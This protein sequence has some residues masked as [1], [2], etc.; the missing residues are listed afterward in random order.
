MILEYEQV[1]QVEIIDR[2][3]QF[4]LWIEMD[5]IYI[6]ELKSFVTRYRGLTVVGMGILF[7]RF[8]DEQ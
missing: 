7:V 6:E 3:E 8:G 1:K 2:F 4:V 5:W